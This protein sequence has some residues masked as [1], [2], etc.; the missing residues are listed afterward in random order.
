MLMM[1]IFLILHRP[2]IVLSSSDIPGTPR[3]VYF[4]GG[5]G[6]LHI[7]KNCDDLLGQ[8]HLTF[9]KVRGKKFNLKPMENFKHGCNPI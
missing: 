4:G 7:I 2:D 5:G 6:E 3:E 9:W 8:L 1:S